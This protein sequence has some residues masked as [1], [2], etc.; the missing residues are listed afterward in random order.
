[1]PGYSPGIHYAHL[2]YSELFS[3]SGEF[4]CRLSLFVYYSWPDDGLLGNWPA[5]VKKLL[6]FKTNIMRI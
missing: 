2:L 1:M 4:V 3:S 5:L 6:T